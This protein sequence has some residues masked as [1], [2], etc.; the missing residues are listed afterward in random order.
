MRNAKMSVALALE[1][2]HLRS[3]KK[4]KISS[5]SVGVCSRT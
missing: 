5:A 4:R 2:V 1:S 3:K